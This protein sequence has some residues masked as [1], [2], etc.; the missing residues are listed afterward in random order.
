MVPRVENY[1][2]FGNAFVWKLSSRY[3]NS[4]IDKMTLRASASTGFRAPSLHQINLQLPRHP[5][6]RGT[7]KDA[8][9]FRNGSAQIKQL[10]VAKL[11]AENS[12]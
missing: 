12:L 7:I 3:I 9:V 11:K 4:M 5:S 1:S 8:G 10:G 6:S 2:D